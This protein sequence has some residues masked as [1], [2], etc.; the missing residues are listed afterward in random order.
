MFWQCSHIQKFWK[1][2]HLGLPHV[3]T[4]KL[5]LLGLT[6]ELQLNTRNRLLLLQLL[7]FAKKLILLH[8]KDTQAPRIRDW[9]QLANSNLPHIKAVYI[10][11]NCP[12][13]FDLIWGKW[14]ALDNPINT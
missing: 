6:E 10:S 2:I 3:A 9:K 12:T 14:I 1:D 13:K 11:R 7:F 4:P 8:W 5:S